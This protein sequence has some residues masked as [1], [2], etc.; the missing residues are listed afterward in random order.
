MPRPTLPTQTLP[1]PPD[2]IQEADTSFFDRLFAELAPRVQGYVRRL[3]GN[4]TDAEDL[5]Q[6]V[7]LAAYSARHSYKGG[8]QPLGWLMGI[9][10]RRWRDKKR[11]LRL[12]QEEM[13][14]ETSSG[15]DIGADV[16]RTVHLEACLEQLDPIAREAVLL[17]FGQGLTYAEA[18]QVLGEPVGTVKWRVHVASK[19]LRTLL[20]DETK[21]DK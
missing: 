5:T 6:E 9:A 17:V 16:I 4:A 2:V 10:R 3:T 14:D 11:G 7:F 15:Q 18:A 13:P 21:E 19:T 1:P 20:R 12:S 8:A